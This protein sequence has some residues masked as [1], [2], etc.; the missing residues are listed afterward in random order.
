MSADN[1]TDT[2]DTSPGSVGDYLNTAG[3]I[4]RAVTGANQQPAPVAGTPAAQATATKTNWLPWII[5][6]VAILAVAGIALMFMR[7]AKA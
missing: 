3:Q 7:K 5:G 2:L 1:S 6:G 4:F